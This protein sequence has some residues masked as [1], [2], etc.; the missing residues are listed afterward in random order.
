MANAYFHLEEFDK[1]LE[2]INQVISVN[3]KVENA[4]LLRGDIY[5]VQGKP[6]DADKNYITALQLNYRSFGGFIGKARVLLSESFAGAAYN[7]IEDAMDVA[8]TPQ[9]EAIALYW[10][11]VA[12]VGLDEMSA[13]IR[14]YEAFLALP[15]AEVPEDLRSQAL[16]EYL[17]IVTPTPSA[18]ATNTRTP[19]S[20]LTFTT[21][22]SPGVTPTK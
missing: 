22:P 3:N 4:Y 16:A 11:A 21:T 6:D 19:G 2:T 15:R 7:Y 17:D 1:A 9:E 13:A 10:R 12:L 14:D 8:D 20:I 5:M 18:A